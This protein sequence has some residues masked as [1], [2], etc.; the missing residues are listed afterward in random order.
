M[1]TAIV[2]LNWNGEKLLEQFLPSV[3][4]HSSE[5]ASIY[6]ADNAS[7]D[8]SIQF[9]K[10]HFPSVEI[11]EN[12]ENGGYAKGYNDALNQVDADLYC[13][14]NSDVEVSKNWLNPVLEIFKND[15]NTAVIQPKL[16]DF[17]DKT[18]F[19]YAGAAGGF[20]D[21]FGYPYCRGR[22][23]NALETD[24]NQY[25]TVDDI[26]WASGACLF[27]RSSVFHELKG[28]DEDYFAHQEEIDLCWRVQNSGYSIKYVPESEVYHVGGATLSNSNPR[29]T[30]LNFR[31]S[32]LNIVKNISI[33]KL[34]LVVLSR[35]ILDGIA[36]I[37]FFFDL[38]PRHTFAVLRAHFSFYW[39]LPKFLKK[40]KG[41]SQKIMYYKH[42]SIVFQYFMLGRKKFDQLQ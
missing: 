36:G 18:K 32:L 21:F 6:V 29:K 3:I 22:V 40:R 2:I 15:R 33:D 25:N 31:N 38:K 34:F 26:F 16:L 30:F 4:E 17:K 14:M 5:L 13:L 42:G 20:L 35:L 23:F 9:V 7:S 10:H 37:K 12:K 27:I 28:F 24:E 41:L 39:Y 19:E 1:K 8:D 11:I